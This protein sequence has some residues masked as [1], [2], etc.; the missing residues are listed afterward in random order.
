MSHAAEPSRY[1]VPTPSF[2][3]L[4]G[5]GAL[6][7][8]AFGAVLTMNSVANG[9]WVL[10]AGFLVL[11]T[12]LVGWFGRVITES[13]AHLYNLQVD[14]SFRLAMAWFIFSEVMFF[15]AFFGALFYVRVLAVPDLASPAQALLWD[16]FANT[17]PTAGPAAKELFTPMHAWG[18]PAINT[19]LLLSSGV[20]ITWAHWGLIEGKRTHL[21]A[22]LALTVL[23]GLVFLSV[24]WV[25]YQEAY[26]HMNLKLTS[27]VYGSTFFMLTGFHGFHV[28][29]GAIMLM[30]ILARAIKGHFTPERHFAFKAVAWYWHFVD[31]VWLILFVVI[32][33]L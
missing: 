29:L 31:V 8:L 2:W 21:V 22:G 30:V 24:Q 19:A 26:D 18:L 6:L 4:V 11:L 25:E 9:A 23:L 28:T 12:M 15:A 7:L 10:L 1:F 27:G 32:Y 17:W 5:S 3:P 33:W 16:G 20:T 14:R 13:E